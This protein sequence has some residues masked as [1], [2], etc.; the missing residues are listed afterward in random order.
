M[1]DQ[2][3]SLL[4]P[5]QPILPQPLRLA[6][7][8][9]VLTLC[10][11][12]TACDSN[13]A[14]PPEEDNTV[15]GVT[16]TAEANPV[17][18]P[19]TVQMT[20]T[21][22]PAGAPQTVTWTSSHPDLATVDGSGLVTAHRQGTFTITATSTANPSKS[23][24]VAL[25]VECPDPRL[26]T[27]NLREDTTWENWVPD[28][29]CFDY[30]VQD[31]L[32]INDTE[33]IIEP[34]AVIGFEAGLGL[35]V[36]SA[37]G[38][39]AV[40]TAEEPILLTGTTKTRGFWKGVSLENLSRTDIV[41]AHTTIEYT[42]GASISGTQDASLMTTEEVTVRI[43]N[44]T[45]RQSSGYGLSLSQHTT[46]TGAGGNT[47]TE[48]ALGSAFAFGAAVKHL[49]QGGSTLTGNDVDVVMVHPTTIDDDAVWATGTYRILPGNGAQA[50]TVTDPGSLTLG[51]GVQLHFEEN[52]ALLVRSGAGFSAVGTAQEP[53]LITGTEAVP[54]HWQGLWFFG[55]D[56]P[57]NRLD[58]VIIEYAG[59][60]RNGFDVNDANL[61]LRPDG[62]VNTMVTVSNTTLRGSA[63]Y[64]LAARTP[65]RL[66]GFENNTM[67]DNALGPAA[68][69]APIVDDLQAS[70]SF[71]GNAID[72]ILV[73]I[74]T[75][76]HLTESL[77]WRNLGVPYFMKRHNSVQWQVQGANTTLTI[78]P[79]VEMRFDELTGVSI[80]QEAT[81]IAVGTAQAPIL[82]RGKDGVGWRGLDFFDGAGTFDHVMIE[83]GGA[84]AWGLVSGRAGSITIR[85]VNT[86]NP[87][88][89][90]ITLTEEVSLSGLEFDVVFGHGDTYATGCPDN[91]S[92]PTND[93]REE[94]CQ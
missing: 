45:F 73:Q 2:T 54:G 58:H 61:L 3:P 47:M 9:L 15:T 62:G 21:V 13:P 76:L 30:I 24:T 14:D 85:T 67:T 22:A 11:W 84:E 4:S 35:R 75:G 51:A 5:I 17:K 37:A 78:E 77:L 16:V 38:L 40:G 74:G 36:R 31:A 92:V 80:Q 56:N 33:L 26:V 41:I 71:A 6:Q 42:G 27:D 86:Q 89:S 87:P 65:A 79:G 64:G 93:S 59:D 12:L 44:S 63:G 50:F 53:I 91:V 46:I 81:L 48:N 34:G 39:N 20:A 68:I 94:H 83:D 32:S 82:L 7:A 52:Q 57:M 66:P 10:V 72:E 29:T 19:T 23:G 60:N 69:D 90:S 8:L 25:G 43:E 1:L 28:P 88:A 70:N 18:L 49:T 55:T